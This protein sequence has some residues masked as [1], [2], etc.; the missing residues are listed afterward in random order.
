MV[1]V[2]FNP[3]AARPQNNPRRSAT[4]ESVS[5][6]MTPIL[7]SRRSATE[8]ILG[9]RRGPWVET[10]GYHRSITARW[11]LTRCRRRPAQL[12]LCLSA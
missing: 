9:V 11:F 3:R 8:W 1:A 4:H 5:G 12:V 2:G 10:H 7:F 6:A